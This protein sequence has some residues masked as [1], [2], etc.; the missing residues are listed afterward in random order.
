MKQ[1]INTENA[2][3]MLTGKGL[4]LEQ[5]RIVIDIRGR[6]W[7]KPVSMWKPIVFGKERKTDKVQTPAAKLATP[8][9]K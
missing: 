5:Q 2:T 8:K 4:T 6:H 7:H 3:I 1:Q 9:K